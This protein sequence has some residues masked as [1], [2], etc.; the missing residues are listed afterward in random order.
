MG[1]LRKYILLLV[2]FVTGASV[3][4]VE[5]VAVR[6]LSPYFGNTIFTVSSV[7]G[8]I[9]AALSFGYYLGGKI[10]DRHPSLKWF[11]GIIF[12]SGLSI[13]IL[14]LLSTVMLPSLGY[15]LSIVSGPLVSAVV[16]F[17]LPA[18]LLGTLSPFAIKLQ[19]LRLPSDG[20]GSVAGGVFFWSTFGSIFG[21]L[22]AGFVLIPHFGINQIVITVGSLLTVMGLFSLTWLR[23]EKKAINKSV[24]VL[25]LVVIPTLIFS[26]QESRDNI[27]YSR[28]GVYEKITIYDGQYNG[29]PTRF[30]RQDRSSSGAM[31]LDCEELVFDY[32]KYYVLYKILKPQTRETLV[33][34]GGAYS[35]PKALLNESPKV[36]VDVSEIEPSLFELSKKYFNVP[37]DPRLKNYVE[38]GRRL[39]Y[40][41][42][43]QYDLIFNDVYYSLLSVPAHFTTEEF[44]RIA[45]NKLSKDGVF[46]A[47][48]VGSLSGQPP[49]LIFSEIRTFKSVFPN[50]YFFAVK[51]PISS[52][53]QNMVL[54]GYNSDKKIDFNNQE[55][56][57]HEN[58]LIRTL[59]QKIISIDGFDLSQYPKLTDNFCPVEYLTTRV[60]R[61]RFA[62]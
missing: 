45:Q 53:P 36:K 54:V 8:V 58:P 62:E 4:I 51:S 60:L 23:A 37:D 32:T 18:L 30:F 25:A 34:G 41:T 50:S 40:K 15:G 24:F 43:K 21:S 9:L 13:L 31:Y 44:F 11:F 6:I 39:L 61:R 57:E 52:R 28:D 55:I 17:S 33:I 5:V 56:T 47:N 10:A 35:I 14:Q 20:I 7:I 48:L 26:Y 49:S 1:L 22:F 3:L 46:I 12:V 19:S 59:G 29:R 42:E 38:D 27:V 16:L 2:V